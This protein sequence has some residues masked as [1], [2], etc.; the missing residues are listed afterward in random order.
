MRVVLAVFIAAALLNI[1]VV[2]G[3]RL[4][5]NT[6]RRLKCNGSCVGTWKK[7]AG[8]GIEVTTM[9]PCCSPQDRCVEKTSKFSQCRPISSGIPASWPSGQILTCPVPLPCDPT[10]IVSRLGGLSA[11][12]QARNQDIRLELIYVEDVATTCLQE[13]Q[14]NPDCYVFDETADGDCSLYGKNLF[15]L[16]G[17][18]H[19]HFDAELFLTRCFLPEPLCDP[20]TP[21]VRQVKSVTR[22]DGDYHW[23]ASNGDWRD[24]YITDSPATFVLPAAINACRLQQH[25]LGGCIGFA[26]DHTPTDGVRVTLL[27]DFIDA[28]QHVAYRGD[29]EEDPEVYSIEA[30]L[31][32]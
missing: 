14:D 26:I 12:R 7:C 31:L 10:S 9:R 21:E 8:E 22:S 6:S 29:L 17:T 5:T 3:S 24:F 11:F 1:A 19:P 23:M 18:L 15:A 32:L 25:L 20:A 16:E 27:Y 2:T 28:D 30:C 4:A 13:C